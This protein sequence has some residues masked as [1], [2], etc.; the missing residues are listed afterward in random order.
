MWGNPTAKKRAVQLSLDAALVSRAERLGGDLGAAAA[1]GIAQ[2]LKSVEQVAWAD[3]NRDAIAAF[4]HHIDA[5][6]TLGEDERH[7]G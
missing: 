5:H 6:G 3:R 1:R 2:H 4:N 7:C